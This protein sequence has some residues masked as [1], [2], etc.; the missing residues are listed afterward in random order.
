M[1]KITRIDDP[2]NPYNVKKVVATKDNMKPLVVKTTKPVE[3]PLSRPKAIV[4]TR[5]FAAGVADSIVNAG[6][7]KL[8]TANAEYNAVRKKKIDDAV[9]GKPRK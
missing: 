2:N 6:R 4:Q 5:N 7:N 1:A 9:D 8:K 3:K